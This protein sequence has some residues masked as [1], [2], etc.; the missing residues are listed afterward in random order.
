MA[1]YLLIKSTHW[2]HNTRCFVKEGQPR[3]HLALRHVC[4]NTELILVIHGQLL[5]NVHACG[6]SVRLELLTAY[7]Q[8]WRATEPIRRLL[9]AELEK[10]AGRCGVHE[11]A[12]LSHH[13]GGAH[14]LLLFIFLFL[15]ILLY[16]DLLPLLL[17]LLLIHLS[18]KISP[19]ARKVNLVDIKAKLVF[20]D[21]LK[22]LVPCP[23]DELS[24][25]QCS[26][27]ACLA[28]W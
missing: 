5:H 17:H 14:F 7:T 28:N 11:I 19:E 25:F 20:W 4:D 23:V 22:V 1:L 9:S 24:N 16:H 27:L 8:G 15:F 6:A 13:L 26:L 12:K 18:A 10:R 21:I 3:R 2:R